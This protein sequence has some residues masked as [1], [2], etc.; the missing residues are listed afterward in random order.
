MS[1]SRP[2]PCRIVAVPTARGRNE[3]AG[4]TVASPP[5]DPFA[6]AKLQ[7]EVPD[8]P[9]LLSFTREY[10]DLAMIVTTSQLRRDGRY[11]AEVDLV[12]PFSA[13]WSE[14][15]HFAGV[16]SVSW[17]GTIGHLTRLRVVSRPPSYVTLADELEVLLRFP[18]VVQN[19]QYTIEAAG[20]VSRLRRLVRGLRRGSHEVHVQRF[21]T[22]FMHARLHGLTPHQYALLQEALS[23]GYFDVPRRIS[24][25]RLAAKL[26]R[27]KSTVSRNL[28]LVEKELA[29]SCVADPH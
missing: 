20:R 9:G 4:P 13:D 12:G 14:I 15:T 22:D 17:L 5:S 26:G 10:S 21:C 19:G 27:S 18:H 2:H 3:L 25:T 11:M 23:A 24:L 29:E 6:V 16:Y 1:A 7:F 8:D 28:A